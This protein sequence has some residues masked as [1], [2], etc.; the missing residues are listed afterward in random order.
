ME[1]SEGHPGVSFESFGVI[2]AVPDRVPPKEQVLFWGVLSFCEKLDF[3]LEKWVDGGY[4]A[5]E[6]RICH[7]KN[8]KCIFSQKS[9]RNTESLT[10]QICVDILEA[11]RSTFLY[12]VSEA[13]PSGPSW[14]PKRERPPPCGSGAPTKC[15]KQWVCLG[16]CCE[17]LTGWAAINGVGFCS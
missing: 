11:F 7:R 13:R 12:W 3:C 5:W 14:R 17:A 8:K 10:T 4:F 15:Q 9:I 1:C 6:N 16:L 2:E